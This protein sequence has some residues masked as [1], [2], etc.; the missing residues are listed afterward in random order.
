VG[1]GTQPWALRAARTRRGAFCS[2]QRFPR[3]PAL[4]VHPPADSASRGAA[5]LLLVWRRLS[6]PGPNGNSFGKRSAGLN[7]S[8][9]CSERMN[10]APL[11]ALH[12]ERPRRELW[13]CRSPGDALHSA[14]RLRS[15]R[16][17]GRSRGER[18]AGEEAHFPPRSGTLSPC[19]P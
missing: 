6:S 2:L 3:S 16:L 18:G 13:R 4:G 5:S 19:S 9:L 7:P 15:R 10:W 12:G 8:Y 14:R 1:P 11:Q 17:A